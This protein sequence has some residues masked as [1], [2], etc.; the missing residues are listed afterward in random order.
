[1]GQRMEVYC[2][3]NIAQDIISISKSF[4][5][6]AKVSGYVEKSENTSLTIKDDKGIYQ[7]NA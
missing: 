5:I 2:P 6:D 4:G 3:Q 7:Y 1:M